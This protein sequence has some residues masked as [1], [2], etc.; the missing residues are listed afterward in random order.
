MT[1]RV[2]SGAAPILE[3][4]GLGKSYGETLALSDVSLKFRSGTVHAILGENGC[5]KSTLVKLLS[6]IVAPSSG[7]IRIL[8]SSTIGR[9]PA[10]I[11]RVG[12]ATVFQE[13]LLAPDRSVTD[14][15]LL[16]TGSLFTR[17]APRTTRN[18]LAASALAQVTTVS[19]DLDAPAGELSLAA[20]QLVVLARALVRA[21]KIL[22]LDEATAALDLADR[23]A[24]FQMIEGHA[25]SGGLVLFISHRMD[26]VLR[27][28]HQVT[29]LRNGRVVETLD[30]HKTTAEALLALMAPAAAQELG[31]VF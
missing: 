5:G 2:D 15:I 4:V 25:R 21:P 26:E 28:A 7:S 13:V 30:T 12:L 16:G 10:E 18:A 1:A 3:I 24:V 6:G 14:N 29:I 17:R 11:Q 9:S 27:L 19:I 20:G 8:D 23:E 22:V 31:H